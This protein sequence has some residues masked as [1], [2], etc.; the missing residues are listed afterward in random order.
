MTTVLG[1]GTT[2][3]KGFYVYSQS[4][5]PGTA[6]ALN[7]F[8]VFNPTASTI[9]TLPLQSVQTNYSVGSSTTATSSQFQRITSVSGGTPV[10]PST[11]PRFLQTMPDPQTQVY[12]NNPTVVTSGGQLSSFPPPISTGVGSGASAVLATPAGASFVLPPG[13]GLVVTVPAG[14]INQRWNLLFV[15]EEV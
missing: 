3:A 14:N 15:W 11:V 1:N 13:T 2:V 7:L 12:I 6:A 4:D 9:V 8:A 10:T 5:I